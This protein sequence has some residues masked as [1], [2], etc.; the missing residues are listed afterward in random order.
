MATGEP[1]PETGVSAGLTQIG[2]QLSARRASDEEARAELESARAQSAN[3]ADAASDAECAAD[4]ILS[5]G[6]AIAGEIDPAPKCVEKPPEPALSGVDEALE[7]ARQAVESDD[8]QAWR[9][10]KRTGALPMALAGALGANAARKDAVADRD[11]Q[12]TPRAQVSTKSRWTGVR[13]PAP[14]DS[15]A[16]HI[17]SAEPA[18]AKGGLLARLSERRPRIAR[19]GAVKSA[20]ERLTDIARTA[21]SEDLAG[22][23]LQ[24]ETVFDAT[25]SFRATVAIWVETSDWAETSDRGETSRETADA[26]SGD[27]AR[28]LSAAVE[29][30]VRSD[31]W[32]FL[33][34]RQGKLR[35]DALAEHSGEKPGPELSFALHLA[36]DQTDETSERALAAVERHFGVLAARR[37][38]A[39][40]LT[41][42]FAENGAWRAVFETETPVASVRL[43]IGRRTPRI[44][45][46]LL[47][48]GAP[49]ALASEEPL[50][51][52]LHDR[53]LDGAALSPE[54]HADKLAASAAGRSALASA[55]TA[56]PRQRF[57]EGRR[58][59]APWLS[60]RGAGRLH[61]LAMRCHP[62]LGMGIRRWLWPVAAIAAPLLAAG[63]AAAAAFHSDVALR[64]GRDGAVGLASLFSV[65]GWGPPSAERTTAAIFVGLLPFALFWV[66]T[67]GLLAHAFGRKTK[68]VL[69]FARR[70]TMRDIFARGPGPWAAM[71]AGAALYA[72]TFF[73]LSL[74]LSESGY[75][76]P[77]A[78]ASASRPGA[79]ETL[80]IAVAA[81]PGARW[82]AP[83]WF[84]EHG[85]AKAF[86]ETGLAALT[87]EC[88]TGGGILRL[89]PEAVQQRDADGGILLAGVPA[90]VV[91]AEWATVLIDGASVQAT[92]VSTG[93]DGAMSWPMPPHLIE[94]MRNGDV[95]S[96]DLIDAVGQPVAGFTFSL[97]GSGAAIDEAIPGCRQL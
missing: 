10:K 82:W 59:Q 18:A 7:I 22:E 60:E 95:L 62:A 29:R 87:A 45:R 71:T 64:L 74:G 51:D 19:G 16:D 25:I 70:L 23:P 48:L 36:T 39:P 72:I 28:R 56:E 34:A 84:V 3:P 15:L 46:D 85:Q 37:G 81:A 57:V 2:R 12:Q 52:E 14:R 50:I 1:T 94:Q 24:V 92:A 77:S 47:A 91:G 90:A 9:R 79:E 6:T 63:L 32:R 8:E 21:L 75:G 67:L 11:A 53:A 88:A 58:D 97:K 83:G 13:A 49:L 93:A 33:N 44:C 65:L 5:F 40:R 55:A 17:P 68:R 89:A 35:L 69:G 41:G 61:D 20:A 42:F 26:T 38:F 78:I 73:G 76:V 80:P 86:D 31:P 54:A 27:G 43:H 66:V 30:L 96:L 4:V